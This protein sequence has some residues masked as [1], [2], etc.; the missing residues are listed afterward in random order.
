MTP[1]GIHGGCMLVCSTTKCVRWDWYLICMYVCV[2]VCVCVYPHIYDQ[3]LDH[4]V[5]RLLNIA[6]TKHL[7]NADSKWSKSW[8]SNVVTVQCVDSMLPTKHRELQDHSRVCSRQTSQSSNVV[9]WESWSG[10]QSFCFGPSRWWRGWSA[11]TIVALDIYHDFSL[12]MDATYEAVAACFI[13]GEPC[14]A[15]WM[16]ARTRL[17][18]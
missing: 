18:V 6:L 15:E 2:C 14:R 3:G 1:T 4:N 11:W 17:G 7:I 5:K 16:N 13:V 10:K 9:S 8:I 12:N